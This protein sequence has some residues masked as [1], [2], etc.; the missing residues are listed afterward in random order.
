MEWKLVVSRP[1]L[2]SFFLFQYKLCTVQGWENQ[3]WENKTKNCPFHKGIKRL[4]QA[5]LFCSSL[6]FLFWPIKILW[7]SSNPL[8]EKKNKWI[9]VH[10]Y[11]Y[12]IRTT[13][14]IRIRRKINY[15]RYHITPVINIQVITNNHTYAYMLITFCRF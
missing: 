14:F 8:N 13:S 4:D 3:I 11:V 7:L 6:G 1:N 9:N 12:F 5:W 10:T 2:V 15:N